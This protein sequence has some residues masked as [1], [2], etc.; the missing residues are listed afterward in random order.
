MSVI[1]KWYAE[2]WDATWR[3]LCGEPSKVMHPKPSLAVAGGVTMSHWTDP[4]RGGACANG[5][6]DGRRYDTCTDWW[7][8]TQRSDYMLWLLEAVAYP[9]DRKLRLLACR[10]VRETRVDDTRTVWDLLTDDR[11]RKAVEVA[12]QYTVGEATKD[13]LEAAESEASDAASSAATS[14]EW[15]AATVAAA[16]AATSASVAAWESAWAAGE[17]ASA[18]ARAARAA[19]TKSARAQQAEIIRDMIPAEEIAPLFE[20][21]IQTLQGEAP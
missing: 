7:R 13:E 17:A 2:W 5:I 11:S 6:A 9:D 8:G 19:A 20:R 21:Y 1:E 3:A 18:A 10:V 15:A 14:A 16:V 12:E 4:L